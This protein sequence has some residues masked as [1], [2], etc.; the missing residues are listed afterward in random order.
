MIKSN[1]KFQRNQEARREAYI[2]TAPAEEFIVPL[3][4]DH[5]EHLLRIYVSADKDDSRDVFALDVGCGR[6]PFRS[7]LEN[8][9]FIYKSLDAVQNPENSIDFICELDKKLPES[10]INET[11]YD[12]ILCTEV[13]EHVAEWD[14]A[15]FNLSQLL[16][17]NGK[18]LITCPHFYLLHET[19]HDFWR[20]TPYALQ[21][22]GEKYNLKI[23]HQV[24]AGDG[25]DILGTLFS[26]SYSLPK[27][28][29]IG[30]RIFNRIIF[31]VIKLTFKLL[32][33]R[34]TQNAIEFKS[35][36]Y[37]SNIVVFEKNND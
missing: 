32:K 34:K 13:L 12:F 24:N 33:E 5:V 16:N 19:P 37:L 31:F 30:D 18:L 28:R 9:G 21:Y 17:T 7:Q 23:L 22:F 29:K 4:Q 1:V 2:P 8:A 10:M 6:Q 20:P 36:F 25:W 11:K 35:P 14:M 26:A 27:T 3:L 15:F